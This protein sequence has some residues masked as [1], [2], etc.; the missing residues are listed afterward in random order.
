MDEHKPSFLDLP[1]ELREMIYHEA[2]SITSPITLVNQ[3]GYTSIDETS[4]TNKSLG[5]HIA[6]AL[7]QVSHQV[8]QEAVA[9]LYCKNV[10]S[11]DFDRKPEAVRR[12]LYPFHC[13][14]CIGNTSN[15]FG[16]S[17]STYH[18]LVR[19]LHPKITFHGYGDLQWTY[20]LSRA[21]ELT[22][23][24]KDLSVLDFQISVSYLSWNAGEWTPYISN[25]PR[26]NAERAYLTKACCNRLKALCRLEGQRI[27]K[28]L[29]ISFVAEGLNT[30]DTSVR[31]FEIPTQA[32]EMLKQTRRL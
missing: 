18:H 15:L 23:K 28:S 11:F 31:N 13:T 26:S 5:E 8:H 21:N 17:R 19:E 20:L 2:L 16:H 25:A 1:L 32:L 7:L 30:A 24:Y 3:K 9:F 22:R 27:S 10:F 14:P 29:K 12:E 6:V 4:E